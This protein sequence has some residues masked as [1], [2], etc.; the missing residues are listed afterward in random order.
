MAGGGRTAL[1]GTL[2]LLASFHPRAPVLA[3]QILSPNG[4][5]GVVSSRTEFP[6]DGAGLG[7]GHALL[8]D[9]DALRGLGLSEEEVASIVDD[10]DA[11]GGGLDRR[12]RWRRRHFPRQLFGGRRRAPSRTDAVDRGDPAVGG[13][14]IAP[15]PLRV[16]ADAEVDDSG[17]DLRGTAGAASEVLLLPSDIDGAAPVMSAVV[18]SAPPGGSSVVSAVCAALLR[19]VAGTGAPPV[20][21]AVTV[22]ARAVAL[23]LAARAADK[24]LRGPASRWRERKRE[25]G[26]GPGSWQEAAA[27]ATSERDRARAECDRA[28]ARVHALS[29]RASG[30]DSALRH[31]RAQLADLRAE[32]EDGRDAVADA[33]EAER[34][35][36]AA[37]LVRLRAEMARVLEDARYDKGGGM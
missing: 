3:G 14:G 23:V 6:A 10:D 32:L 37:E 20:A 33:V 25:G 31:H 15:P 4:R 9:A 22:A 12:R 16:S 13:D 2:L 34:R 1:C 24:I 26:G 36:A 7:P 21:R 17:A 19:M 11:D 18:G 30:L 29:L 5:S 28:E 8:A 27:T 35:R